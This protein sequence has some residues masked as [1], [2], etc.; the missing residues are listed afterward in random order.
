ML[1]GFCRYGIAFVVSFFGVAA[2]PSNLTA[3]TPVIDSEPLQFVSPNW[4]AQNRRQMPGYHSLCDAIAE[5]FLIALIPEDTVGLTLTGHPS[6]FLYLPAAKK[7]ETLTVE[8]AIADENEN[9]IYVAKLRIPSQKGVFRVSLPPEM[10]PLEV[11]K[12]YQW[13]FAIACRPEDLIDSSHFRSVGG[14]IRRIHPPSTLLKDLAQTPRE[15]HPY[16]YARAGIWHDALTTLADLEAAQPNNPQIQN[17]WI[18][19]LNSVG[20]ENLPN[21]QLP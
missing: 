18:S 21:L 9:E 11:D 12:S 7:G 6:F 3:Q 20:L 16:L 10:S 15:Q 14:V 4:P 1:N 2:S 8:L 13:E 17:A 19:L 5:Q